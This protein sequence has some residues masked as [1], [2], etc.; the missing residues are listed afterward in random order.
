MV[1]RIFKKEGNRMSFSGWVVFPFWMVLVLLLAPVRGSTAELSAASDVDAY[2]Q[3]GHWRFDGYFDFTKNFNRAQDQSEISTALLGEYFV[4]D[5]LAVGVIFG[6][7]WTTFDE[8]VAVIGPAADF[9]FW[10]KERLASFVGVDYRFG[11]T[12]VTV[13]GVAQ[14]RAGIQYFFHPA[15]AVGPVFF[16]RH[17]ISEIVDYQRLGFTVDFAVFL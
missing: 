8:T 13:T 12:D 9:Y 10:K 16:F 3:E 5:R 17:Y 4:V 14:G 6:L 11:L 7:D 1:M 2:L 15:A